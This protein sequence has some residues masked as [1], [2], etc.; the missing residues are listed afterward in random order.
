MNSTDYPGFR[1]TQFYVAMNRVDKR[2][3]VV[4]RGTS[5]VADLDTTLQAD[6]QGFGPAGKAHAGFADIARHARGVLERDLHLTVR[7]GATYVG[8]SLGAS[9]S[10][11]MHAMASNAQE[12]ALAYN[13]APLPVFDPVAA[14]YHATVLAGRAYN[15]FLEDEELNPMSRGFLKLAGTQL[16][17]QSVG[18]TAGAAHFVINY[19][20][21]VLLSKGRDLPT[22]ENSLALC[23]REKFACFTGQPEVLLP[24]CVLMTRE[25][26]DRYEALL[27]GVATVNL[28]ASSIDLAKQQALARL[29][30]GG[31]HPFVQEILARRLRID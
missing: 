30:E 12:T 11:L 29:G 23:V 1:D 9:V 31:Q 3:Y 6:L 24:A 25:C 28:S 4:V 8:H 17:L 5:G 26:A 27:R 14:D 22:Y 21:S 20:R 2:V 19:L 15:L 16:T 18:K 13:F 7:E 10:L